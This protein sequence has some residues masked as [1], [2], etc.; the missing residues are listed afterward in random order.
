MVN[1]QMTIA[2]TLQKTWAENDTNTLNVTQKTVLGYTVAAKTSVETSK[3][4]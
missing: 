2:V 4:T 1:G 3:D